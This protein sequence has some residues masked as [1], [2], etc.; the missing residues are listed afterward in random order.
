ME[1][2][3]LQRI[4]KS[5]DST[6]NVKSKE[7]LNTMLEKKTRKTMNKFYYFIGI[8][9]VIS[10]G[11]I[12]FLIITMINRWEDI[13]YRINNLAICTFTTI[14]LISEIWS[15]Y[16][17]RNNKANLPIKE[18]LEYRIKLLTKDLSRKLDYYILPFIA[19]PC[20]LSVSVYYNHNSFLDLFQDEES[21]YGLIFGLL[22]CLIVSYITVRKIRKY[23]LKNLDHLKE[24]HKML[25]NSH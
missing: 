13:Y 23:H 12:T 20:I 5:I 14:A 1:N 15:L 22:G 24:L 16:A 9:I 7:E 2:N 11:F 18:W 25:S 4:W 10:V 6:I 17:L 21:I 8:A 3:E 19:V